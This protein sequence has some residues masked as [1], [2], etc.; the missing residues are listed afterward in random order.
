MP[1]ADAF[2]PP[3]TTVHQDFSQVGRLCIEK[4]LRQIDS[5]G[6]AVPGT[7]IVPT[8]LV[9]RTR[10]APPPALSAHRGSPRGCRPSTLRRFGSGHRQTAREGLPAAAGPTG[11]RPRG[12]TAPG[13]DGWCGCKRC[14][15]GRGVACCRSLTRRSRS[16]PCA[17]LRRPAD[18][19]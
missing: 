8:H 6:A 18:L 12:W 13:S 3:L 2:W 1:E 7:T 14:R 4:P 10:T 19:R 17:G 5:P 16:L 15:R 11:T 9:V